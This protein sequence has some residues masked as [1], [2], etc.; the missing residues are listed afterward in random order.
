MIPT[1]IGSILS[2]FIFIY[3][4]EYFLKLAF[5]DFEIKINPKTQQVE[6]KNTKWKKS[7]IMCFLMSDILKSCFFLP[8]EARKQ[9]F[10]LAQNK[11]YLY[12]AIFVTN[13]LKA[14]PI[15]IFRDCLIRI[16]NL[17]SFFTLLDVTHN[18]TLK[19]SIDKIQAIIKYSEKNK[20]EFDPSSVIDYSNFLDNSTFNKRFLTVVCSSI[21]STFITHPIDVLI[22][23]YLTQTD[24]TYKSYFQ[25]ILKIYKKEGIKKLSISGFA[26]RLSFNLLSAL[27][28]TTFYSVFFNFLSNNILI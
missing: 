21:F 10:Q 25:S 19:Y 15:F 12:N 26:P 28:V 3:S 5:K 22:T 7:L 6:T 9:R 4:N 1:S 11:E 23:K 20:S 13:C 27:N 24:D 18:P 17:I 14:F 16:I 2:S 8:F